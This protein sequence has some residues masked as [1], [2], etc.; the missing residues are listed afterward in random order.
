VD[1]NVSP[2]IRVFALVGVLAALALAGGMFFLSRSATA[3]DEPLPVPVAAKPKPAATAEPKPVAKP[4]PKAK[5]AR[6]P[7]VIAPNG[8]PRVIATQLA[9]HRVVV[10]A[11][12]AGGATVD[13]LARDEARAGADD[14]NVGF[15]AVDVSN[16]RVALAL[17]ERASALEAPAVLVFTKDTEVVARLDGFAD[18]VLVAELAA[19]A[20]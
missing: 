11:L 18:R 12:Y 15:A 6:R 19:A 16:R 7:G 13:T 2:Q 17:A 20:K 4:K 3:A 9:K 14:A 1:T 5:P 8:L 10:A